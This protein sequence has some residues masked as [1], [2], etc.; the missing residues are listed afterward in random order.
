MKL[1]IYRLI[2]FLCVF[3]LQIVLSC[4]LA[5]L[6]GDNSIALL[7]S[8]VNEHAYSDQHIGDFEEDLRAFRNMFETANVR[9]EVI[10]DKDLQNTAEKLGQYK[11]IIVPLLVDIAG[12]ELK[13]LEHFVS[14]GGK[15]IVSDGAGE[16]SSNARQL[17]TLCGAKVS[18][19][20]TLEQP[21]QLVWE[22]SPLAVVQDFAVGTL[23]AVL[24]PD[25]KTDAIAKWT[26]GGNTATPIDSGAALCSHNGSSFISWSPAA[27]GD[28]SNN[29]QIFSLLLEDAVPGITQQAA[30]QIS[31][32]DY[33]TTKQDLEYLVKRTDEVVN[34]A[35]QADISVPFKEIQDD[36]DRAIQLI[37]AYDES[38][39][40]RRFFEAEQ[41]VQEARRRL[42]IAFAKAMPV[43][44]VEMRAVWLDR[45][46]IV[47]NRG[48]KAMAA[49]IEK[50]HNAGINCIYFETNNSGFSMYPSK[51]A[52]MNPQLEGWDALAAAL[53]ESKKYGIEFHPWLWVFNVGNERHN[54]IIGRQSDYPGPVLTANKFN[55]ALQ[56]KTG[57]L[58]AHNQHEFWVDPANPEV[59]Q[60]CKDLILE[61]ATKYDVDG[62]QYDYIRYPF[63]MRPN[64][65]GWDWTGRIRFERETGF[66][67]DNMSDD[68]HEVWRVWRMQQVNDFVKDTSNALRTLKPKLKIAAAVY[69][70]PKRLRM[71][72]VLQEWEAWVHEGSIDTINPM[73]YVQTAS[74]L[75][76]MA[77]DCRENSE[78][79][80]LVFPGLSIRQL[81]T[82]G[83]IEQLDTSRAIGTLGTTLFAVAQLDD[84]KL[85]LL[86]VG[87]Y[88]R[89]AAMTPQADPLKAGRLLVDDFVA[90]VNKYMQDPKKRVIA[91]TASTNTVLA[92]IGKL[93][94]SVH[95]LSAESS[96]DQIDVTKTEVK[97][98]AHELKE[99]LRIDAFAQRGFRAQ[100]ILSY[101]EQI[102]AL[103]SYAS[104]CSKS[105]NAGGMAAGRT[106]GVF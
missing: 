56:S 94:K 22:R 2:V 64:E 80:A 39:K 32:A 7:Q 68:S 24:S 36:Y 18:G 76:F 58:Y 31:F 55:W 82:A 103:L 51:M 3:L 30:V 35:K 53:R 26:I 38:Y 1:S 88:R 57:S 89:P 29:C 77:T 45:G 17:L 75:K 72:N 52:V 71:S 101:L 21:S 10:D 67:L 96:H 48:D 100:Y 27:Q 49:L 69:G 87:P 90:M 44:P 16:L 42:A 43:R 11:V 93:Q 95:E 97:A 92:N 41:Q 5:C 13:A 73:T 14:G 47:A 78:D 59:R 84:S 79:K 28:I 102:E 54:P 106:T 12:D 99:W 66:S 8:K 9:Y 74:N 61:V 46:T 20:T 34:T 91:D 86:R 104:H 70:F 25:S 4:F 15:L 83:F 40:Q 23:V 60:Y 6:A 19:H 85:E 65:M 81:D 50:L 63:N 62:I 98:L 33:Q 105:Q 37:K